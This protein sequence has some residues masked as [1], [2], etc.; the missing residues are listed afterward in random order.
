M[1]DILIMVIYC[2]IILIGSVLFGY[3]AIVKPMKETLKKD[4]DIDNE[5]VPE[6]IK[7]IYK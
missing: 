2:C 6:G 1:A 7:A 4:K 5:S 3:G